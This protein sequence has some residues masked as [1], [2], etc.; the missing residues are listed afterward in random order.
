MQPGDAVLYRGIDRR[1][2]RTSPNPN[3]WSAHLFCHWV[4]ADG[5]YRH[6]AFEDVKA[7][8]S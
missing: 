5:P 2:G 8:D 6:L 7:A 3:Q 1:H 4:A